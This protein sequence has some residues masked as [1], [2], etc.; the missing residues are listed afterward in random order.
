[1]DRGEYI[2]GD[3]GP[4]DHGQSPYRIRKE[5]TPFYFYRGVGPKLKLEEGQMYT[6]RK[7]Q[8]PNLLWL[9]EDESKAG[10]EISSFWGNDYLPLLYTGE[11]FRWVSKEHVSRGF[12]GASQQYFI[13][14][15]IH[16]KVCI[17]QRSL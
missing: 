6:R 16:G 13:F 10:G 2:G 17:E 8:E 4:E 11:S 3:Y 9:N 1:M 15:S 14:F 12:Y 5:S 7:W